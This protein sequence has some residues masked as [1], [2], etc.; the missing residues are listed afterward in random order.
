MRV[1]LCV[2][3]NN[4]LLF[5]ERRPSRD[6]E[7]VADIERTLQ[8][9]PIAMSAY[10]GKL[11]EGMDNVQVTDDFQGCENVFLEADDLANLDFNTLVVYR[12]DKVYPA[13]VALSYDLKSLK[14]DD[15]S[16]IKGYSHDEIVK[17]VYTR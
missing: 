15:V 9:E 5:N 4:G 10:S 2:D 12:W 14:L 8:G 7:V 1:F 16:V 13:D 17:E 3:Q 11:F 6:R